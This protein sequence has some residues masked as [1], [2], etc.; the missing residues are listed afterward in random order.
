[1]SSKCSPQ[2]NVNESYFIVIECM[3]QTLAAQNKTYWTLFVSS[4]RRLNFSSIHR[5]FSAFIRRLFIR[6][7]QLAGEWSTLFNATSTVLRI[8]VVSIRFEDMRAENGMWPRWTIEYSTK[9]ETFEYYSH[10]SSLSKNSS[11]IVELSLKQIIS[12]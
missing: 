1:M 12:N 7:F 2:I 11:F 8:I 6:C 10:L 4:F 3:R 9:W 5:W